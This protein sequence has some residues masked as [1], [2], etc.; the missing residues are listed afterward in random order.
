MATVT[1]QEYHGR[2]AIGSSSNNFSVG[3]NAVTLTSSYYYIAKYTGE[4]TS[5]LCETMQAAIRAVSGTVSPN[6][7]VTYSMATGRITIALDSAQ[8]ITWT[9]AALQTI[10]GFTGAQSGSATYTATYQ[11]RY[12]WRPSRGLSSYPL[13]LER[14]WDPQATS[15]FTRAKDGAVHSVAGHTI[16]AAELEYQAL[17]AGDVVVG[18]V[19]NYQSFEQFYLDVIS[20]GQPMRVYP[21]R[22]NAALQYG[23]VWGDDNPESVA[24]ASRRTVR[25][26]SGYYDV[27]LPLWKV[28]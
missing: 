11:P 4:S 5:Q 2:F 26:Y 3:A 15:R 22:S 27:R 6:A 20:A 23:A 25:E 17:P 21:D 1:Y 18:A 24:S 8:T 28:T 9:D 13:T 10:L 12:T 7:N 14:L 19:Q 16:Y